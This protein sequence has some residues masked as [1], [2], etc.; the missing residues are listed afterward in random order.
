M[1]LKQYITEAIE[2]V[3]NTKFHAE[4]ELANEGPFFVTLRHDRTPYYERILPTS[5]EFLFVILESYLYLT[6]LIPSLPALIMLPAGCIVRSYLELAKHSAI[7]AE[8]AW[9]TNLII[10][11]ILTAGV[12]IGIEN[13]L[14]THPQGQPFKDDDKES[15]ENLN[16]LGENLFVETSPFS[17]ARLSAGLT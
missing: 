7:I 16:A 1:Q 13:T 2:K 11:G 6:S 12:A 4:D 14:K 8:S 17:P 10:M 9:F 5:G 3:Q 15:E